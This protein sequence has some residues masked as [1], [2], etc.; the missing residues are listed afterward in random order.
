RTVGTLEDPTAQDVRDLKIENLSKPYHYAAG[1]PVYED[2]VSGTLLM[3]YHAEFYTFPPGWLPFFSEL[4]LARSTDGG[5]TWTDLGPIVT[6][7]ASRVRQLFH[8]RSSVKVEV[9]GVGVHPG[10]F[11]QRNGTEIRRR[12]QLGKSPLVGFVG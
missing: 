9:A 5:S 10:T 7:H 6:P 11:A 12:H 3:F 4:G 8:E 2:R 1:G